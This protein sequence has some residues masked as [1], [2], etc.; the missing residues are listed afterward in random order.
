MMGRISLCESSSNL[1]FA[2]I[3]WKKDTSKPLDVMTLLIVEF[4][5][6]FSFSK[7]IGTSYLVV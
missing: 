3:E 5:S 2:K 1:L 7:I 4:V 6:P